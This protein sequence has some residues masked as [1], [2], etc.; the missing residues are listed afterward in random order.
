MSAPIKLTVAQRCG[1]ASLLAGHT[2]PYWS[3]R[4]ASTLLAAGFCE[5]LPTSGFRITD[6]GRAAL[7]A[8][9]AKTKGV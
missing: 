8:S 5:P 6:A 3:E 2:H 7:A 4:T 1:L 9:R